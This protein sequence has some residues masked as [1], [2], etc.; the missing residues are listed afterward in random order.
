MVDALDH[1]LIVILVNSV[2]DYEAPRDDSAE[3]ADIVRYLLDREQVRPVPGGPKG[4][5]N[6]RTQVVWTT[7]R[8]YG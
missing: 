1:Q 2:Q 3:D 7:G 5:V 8:M 6:L 4:S